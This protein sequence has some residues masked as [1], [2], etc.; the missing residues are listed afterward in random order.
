MLVSTCYSPKVLSL[1]W[2]V[3]GTHGGLE[4]LRG[5]AEV[6]DQKGWLCD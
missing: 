5:Q 4:K 2:S 6:V 3:P 1:P